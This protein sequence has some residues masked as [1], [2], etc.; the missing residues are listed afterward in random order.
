MQ[1]TEK[2]CQDEPSAW[3]GDEKSALNK[4]TK[5]ITTTTTT[6]VSGVEGDSGKFKDPRFYMGYGVEKG[7][8]ESFAEEA[9][10]PNSGLRSAEAQ[11]AAM[12]RVLC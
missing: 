4:Y 6:G 12:P 5:A 11:Q 3:E 9:L 1:E 8:K 10:Q 2:A 7:E